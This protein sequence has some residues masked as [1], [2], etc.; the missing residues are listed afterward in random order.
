ML[1]AVI[2]A[3]VLGCTSDADCNL[4]GVCAKKACLCDT[5]WK[6]SD[7]GELDVGV[8]LENNGYFA[9]NTS[10]WGGTML[11]EGIESNG[12]AMM[13]VSHMTQNCGLKA[14]TTNSEIAVLTAPSP[15]GPFTW[16]RTAIPRFAHNPIVIRHA[17]KYILYHIGCG[18]NANGT[19][20]LVKQCKNGTTPL[21]F[22]KPGGASCN[23]PHYTMARTSDSLEGP[24]ESVG[25]VL[26][27][28]PRSTKW[29]TNPA[30]WFLADGTAVTV[31]RQP[32][33]AWPNQTASSERLGFAKT[34]KPCKVPGVAGCEWVDQSPTAPLFPF[35]VEDQFLWQDTR[36]N[37]HII[38]HKSDPNQG[39]HSDAGH[40]FSADLGATW[41]FS[42]TP[43]YNDTIPTAGGA[44]N[45]GK[46]ARPSLVLKGGKPAYLLTGCGLG[47]GDRTRTTVQPIN[48]VADQIV[49]KH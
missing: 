27:S 42:G 20:P 38:T 2:A 39:G 6:G 24:W 47:G 17:D 11:V 14:W 19:E 16:A 29:T 28:T 37:L 31:Y 7:C 30:V 22:P 34:T 12:S 1:V 45:C 33:G 41:H 44:Q 43:P 26:I 3:A 23:G 9:A 32:A 18:A 36:G 25:E 10:S 40:A 49:P 13:M 15:L 8:T 4:N 35:A 46:R 5:A 48:G 21:P